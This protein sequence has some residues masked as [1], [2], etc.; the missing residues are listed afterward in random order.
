ML[1]SGLRSHCPDARSPGALCPVAWGPFLCVWLCL[2][3]L[4]AHTTVDSAT[5]QS[6]LRAGSF[7]APAAHLLITVCG[8][9]PLSPVS[10]SGVW[11]QWPE[12]F[13]R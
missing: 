13:Q 11:T 10:H 7:R 6:F 1:G 4:A 3:L 8:L 5:W 2:Q 12:C 9:A